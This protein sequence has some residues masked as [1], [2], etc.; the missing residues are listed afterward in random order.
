M[1]RNQELNTMYDDTCIK[2]YDPEE[3]K[4]IGVFKNYLKAGNRLGLT[5]NVVMHRCVSKSRV[6]SP[7][8]QKEVAL[9]LSAVKPDDVPL[10]ERNQLIK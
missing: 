4:L 10:L 9:R 3:K 8:L 6:F 2:V 7:V 5:T 1:Q